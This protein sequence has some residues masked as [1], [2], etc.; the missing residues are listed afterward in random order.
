MSASDP[1]EH[2]TMC[3]AD[4]DM[5]KRQLSIFHHIYYKQTEHKKEGEYVSFSAFSGKDREKM[6]A[7]GPVTKAS[8]S[9]SSRLWTNTLFSENMTDS[10]PVAFSFIMQSYYVLLR[11]L[12]THKVTLIKDAALGRYWFMHPELQQKTWAYFPIG[13][14][15][16]SD[17]CR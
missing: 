3:S 4:E 5:R 17:T 7:D 16:P 6:S 10:T 14:L 1:K 2:M 8:V 13:V 12:K 11:N 15:T 9:D